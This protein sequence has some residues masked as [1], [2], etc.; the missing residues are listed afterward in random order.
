MDENRNDE[1]EK[2]PSKFKKILKFFIIALVL[3]VIII[4]GFF[5]G[6]Y[7]RIIDT[8]EANE[9]YG[10]YDMPVIGEYFVRPVEDGESSVDEATQKTEAKKEVKKDDKKNQSKPVVL[11]KE[12]IEKQ[13]KERQAAE[14][15]RV[16]KLAR[17][18]NEMKPEEAAKIMEGMDDDI[19]ISIL[20]RMDE[21]QVSQVLT[22]FD[23]DRAANITRIMYN[24]APKRPMQNPP[25]S[26]Q[27]QPQ[28]QN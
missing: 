28:A 8:N 19:V 21:S 16:S 7:F 5:L 25:Q 10:L 12:E 11:S 26:E 9:K 13:T 20:Q 2:K 4:V 3:L 27:N 15:K 22:K 6:I 24:G 17:L 18:Y 14:K 23:T 1:A